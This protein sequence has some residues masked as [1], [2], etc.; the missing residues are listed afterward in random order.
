[1]KPGLG[2]NSKH[3]RNASTGDTGSVGE[4]P[5]PPPPASLA[6]S[7]SSLWVHGAGA[8]PLPTAT[9]TDTLALSGHAGGAS[10][11]PSPLSAVASTPGSQRSSIFGKLKKRLSS[12][13]SSSPAAVPSSPTL[14]GAT[15]VHGSTISLHSGSGSGSLSGGGCSQSPSDSLFQEAGT[16]TAAA[17]GREGVGLKASAAAGG[18]SSGD[19]CDEAEFGSCYSDAMQSPCMSYQQ[20]NMYAGGD[21]LDLRQV[22][23]R[24][25]V[26][27]VCI[28]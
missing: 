5:S 11:S 18:G 24:G 8:S 23:V 10:S 2:S 15:P 1:M 12:K 4:P 3:R 19:G 25:R 20:D 13:G 9:A 28:A 27:E 21:T 7:P 22:S 26:R 16:V 6:D 17:A 14:A